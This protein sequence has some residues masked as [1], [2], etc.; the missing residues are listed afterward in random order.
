V[1]LGNAPCNRS[2][3][4]YSC[5]KISTIKD[6]Q[7]SLAEVLFPEY[8]RRVLGLLLL[9]PGQRYHVREISRLTS[10]V[11]GTTARELS[12]LAE[13]G[14]LERTRTGNQVLYAAN[15]Q[16]PVF[17]ELASILRKT[18]GLT[19]VLAQA[20]APLVS[21]IDTAFVFGSIASGKASTGSDVDLMIIGDGLGYGEVVSL[22]YQQQ[23]TL[24][25]EINPKVYD[26]KEWQRL[27]QENGSF[28][29]D[30]M[31]KP[32]LFV[33]GGESE[34]GKLGEDRAT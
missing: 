22:L 29:R 4:S 7:L 11:S 31:S 1:L 27:A 32:K 8:R 17:E 3:K 2:K 20:L 6:W 21:R 13:V 9:H 25:R 5:S 10:T 14:L 30:I 33:I 28:F 26:L 12:R 24:G 19:D 15:E 34:L 18:S 16:C 23:E